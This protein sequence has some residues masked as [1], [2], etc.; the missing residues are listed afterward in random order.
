MKSKSEKTQT[1]FPVVGIG[2]SA[3]G[4]AAFNQ[5]LEVIPED[6]GIAF[7]LIQHLDPNHNNLLAHLLSKHTKMTVLQAEH[8]MQVAPNHVYMIPPDTFITISGTTLKLEDR[9]S[10]KGVNLP[11]D[12]FFRSLAACKQ[13]QAIAIVLS[14]TGADG[15]LGLRAIKEVGGFTIVQTPDSAEFSAMPENAIAAGVV[16]TEVPIESMPEVIL[17]HI[18]SVEFRDD[19]KRPPIEEPEETAD[20]SEVITLLRTYA[21]Y[22]F[23]WYKKG[24]LNRRI[25]RRM[26]AR[27][28]TELSEYTDI[29]RKDKE[30]RD[31]L[32][33]DLLINVT[34]FFRDPEA[35][36]KLRTDVLAPLVA[37]TRSDTLRVWVPGCSTGEEA[38]SLAILFFEEFHKQGKR[39]DLQIFATDL[40]ADA[41]AIARQGVYPASIEESVPS[42]L[43]EAYFSRSEDGSFSIHKRIRQPIIF[44]VQN[45]ISDACFSHLHLITCRNVLIYLDA[46]I[47]NKLLQ[48]FNYALLP[49]G[50]LFLGTSESATREP[51]LFE[52]ISKQWKIY[53]TSKSETK[54]NTT[55]PGNGAES[56]MSRATPSNRFTSFRS[57]P[58]LTEMAQRAMLNRFAPASVVINKKF[59]VKVF[60]GQLRN[61]LAIPAGEPTHNLLA[62]CEPDL[63]SA[64][65]EAV[66]AVLHNE[67]AV[68]LVAPKVRRKDKNTSVELFAELL[69]TDKDSETAI[70][71]SFREQ[72]QPDEKSKKSKPTGE[73]DT[74]KK[75]STLFMD[76]NSEVERLEHELLITRE[77]LQGTIEELETI[78]EE[79]KAANEEVM[80]MNEE[81]QS[82]NEELESSREEL[83]S[84]NQKLST[85]NDDLEENVEELEETNNDLR[86]LL[87]SAEIATIFLDTEFQI[88]R[89]TPVTRKLLRV[90]DSDIGRSIRD[91]APRF[92]DS[93][94]YKDARTVLKKLVPIEREVMLQNDALGEDDQ[95]HQDDS[96][97]ADNWFIRKILPYRTRENN[98]DGVVITFTDVTN[99]KKSQAALEK[100]REFAATIVELGSLVHS[101]PSLEHFFNEV[102]LQV[103]V[104]LHNDSTNILYRLP[105]QETLLL[106]AGIGW[107]DGLV[108]TATVG[109]EEH[110]QVGY[111]LK[112]GYPVVVSDYECETRFQASSLLRDHNIRSSLSVVIGPSDN[113]WGILGTHNRSAVDFD[114]HDIHFVQS[115]ANI[116]WQAIQKQEKQEVLEVSER[117]WK[118]AL[119]G[120]GAGA[121][122]LVMSTGE[123]WTSERHD[124]IFGYSKPVD[125]SF[126]RL[127]EHILPEDRESILQSY[128]EAKAEKVDWDFECRIKR[129]DGELRWIRARGQQLEGALYGSGEMWGLTIDITEQKRLE[130]SLEVAVSSL[131]EANTRKDRFMAMLGHELRNPLASIAS[132]C[133]LLKKKTLTPD[134][135]TTVTTALEREVH[136]MTALVNDLLDLSRIATGNIT[137]TKQLL[138][139]EE[140]CSRAVEATNCLIEERRQ[141]ITIRVAPNLVILADPQRMLQILEN[142]ISNASKYTQEQGSISITAEKLHQEIVISVRDNGIGI[143]PEDQERIFEPFVQLKQEGKARE[144]LGIG[145]NLVCDLVSRHGGRIEVESDGTGTGSCF[146]I[147]LPVPSPT[148]VIA[149]PAGKE[150]TIPT[151]FTHRQRILF[152]EDNQTLLNHFSAVLEDAGASV[153]TAQNGAEAFSALANGDFDVV[154]TDIGLPDVSGND[155]AKK[156]RETNGGSPPIIIGIT[157]YADSRYQEDAPPPYFDF[158][159][160]KPATVEQIITAVNSCTKKGCGIRSPGLK[161]F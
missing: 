157:G 60:H 118:S 54:K 88:R 20:Y 86:N 79:L 143:A 45:L 39:L 73:S 49:G 128:E 42:D 52:A 77:D 134:L 81:L 63:R 59:D 152:I 127:L 71:I 121:W 68:R 74:T 67:G 153:R 144:G 147:F 100:Q 15:T 7:V 116:V 17:D 90:I 13:K 149:T 32:F 95:E 36:E 123:S 58:P 109:S 56:A 132:G 85:V 137:I 139:L 3:G 76:A 126:E 103:N 18:E 23:R 29:L 82:S 44:A 5:F 6:T 80:S 120:A 38:Y 146:T 16:D 19:K 158:L 92:N 113:A 66:T 2:A 14:G 87:D 114:V 84:L 136:D 97:I 156:I 106:K 61:Y 37:N 138:S 46:S 104:K 28:I 135:L 125:W 115:A 83:H 117:R 1:D 130:E 75:D 150:E 155:I 110:T 24:T 159:F 145:L 111:T 9:T 69:P 91:L 142:L 4:L 89:F 35:W 78:N 107:N 154:L 51:A 65:R 148:D 99:L 47:Q 10:E 34:S 21:D 129:T 96:L 160:I 140:L 72:E 53:K 40:D 101:D 31:L 62:L 33:R 25:H 70:L 22:D 8:D 30:E 26:V 11:I 94:L 124:E 41:I 27:S 112:N 57:P 64:L 105:T 43:L 50:V 98:I 108:G 48:M 55:A 151:T 141:N 102:A 12:H 131:K 133:K 93:D 161:N 122:R 119:D